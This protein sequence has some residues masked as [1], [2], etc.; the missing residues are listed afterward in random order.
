M[1]EIE[2][3]KLFQSMAVPWR[4]GVF[5]TVCGGRVMS[6]LFRRLVTEVALQI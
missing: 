3:A 4:K 6:K 1:I 5:E 2:L